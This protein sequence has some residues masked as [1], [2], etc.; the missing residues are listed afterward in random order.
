MLRSRVTL[1][2]RTLTAGSRGTYTETTKDYPQAAW[3][4]P[5][6][7]VERYEA[8]R[9]KP[10]DRYNVVIRF[11]GDANG[12]PFFTISDRVIYQTREWAIEGVED[13]GM[14]GKWLMLRCVENKPT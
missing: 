14:Q 13:V 3:I 11:R 5:V 12:N 6:G 9:V 10:G 8:M 7:G 1:R 4:K 2:T